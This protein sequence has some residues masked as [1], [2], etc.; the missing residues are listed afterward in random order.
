[1]CGIFRLLFEFELLPPFL[2]L[3][4]GQVAFPIYFPES[5]HVVSQLEAPEAPEGGTM[6]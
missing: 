5:S 2:L 4:F 1:M 3:S 6:A